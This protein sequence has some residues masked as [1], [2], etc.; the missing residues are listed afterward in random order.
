M[1]FVN[2]VLNELKIKFTWKGKGI[3]SVCYASGTKNKIVRVDRNYFRPLEVD[4]L[5]GNSTKARRELNWRP[6]YNIKSMIKEMVLE[7]MNLL[8]NDKKIR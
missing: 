3:N 1:Q 4:T 8:K 2:L 6:K 7:E 5:L